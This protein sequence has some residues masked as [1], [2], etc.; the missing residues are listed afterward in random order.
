MGFTPHQLCTMAA[1]WPL[2]YDEKNMPRG[3][4]YRLW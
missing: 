2:S 1:M 4:L 3:R